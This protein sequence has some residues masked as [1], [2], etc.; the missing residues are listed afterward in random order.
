MRCPVLVLTPALCSLHLHLLKVFSPLEVDVL[1]ELWK[2]HKAS[3][4]H[5]ES[6]IPSHWLRC[7]KSKDAPACITPTVI[8]IELVFGEYFFYILCLSYL[9]VYD[10]LLNC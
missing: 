2:T 4:R 5:Y 9:S 8:L 6:H 3:R 1:K 10:S 7:D